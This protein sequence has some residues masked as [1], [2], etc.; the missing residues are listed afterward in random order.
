MYRFFGLIIA[1]FLTT[2]VYAVENLPS[3]DAQPPGGVWSWIRSWVGIHQLTVTVNDQDGNPVKTATVMVG[4]KP[5][6]PFE[7]NIGT[8]D[9]NGSITFQDDALE[10][11]IPVTTYAPGFNAYTIFDL[12]AEQLSIKLTPRSSTEAWVDATGSF[13]K[14]HPYKDNDDLVASGIFAPLLPLEEIINFNLQALLGPECKIVLLDETDIPCNLVF[15]RQRNLYGGLIPITMNKPS[16][17]MKVKDRR[18]Q[19]FVSLAG[20]L[21]L[22]RTMDLLLAGSSFEVAI[23]GLALRKIG[24]AMDVPVEGPLNLN[25]DLDFIIRSNQI[26]VE[27]ENRPIGRSMLLLSLADYQ[28]QGA[29]FIPTGIRVIPRREGFKVKKLSSVVKTGPLANARDVVLAVAIDLPENKNDN[30][31]DSK[32]IGIIERDLAPTEA[33][34]I[35]INSFFLPLDLALDSEGVHLSEVSNPRISPF[36]DFNLVTL[37]RE[38]DGGKFNSTHESIWTVVTPAQRRIITL[39]EL[40]VDGIIPDPTVTPEND[41]LYWSAGVFALA[42]PVTMFDYN[43]LTARDV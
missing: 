16:Y 43:H 32:L 13:S 11:P 20:D 26:E 41:K 14:W 5:G 23:D 27:V 15:P 19:D 30:D 31:N 1:L 38:I 36:P 39:P 4:E 9:E 18:T 3:H 2:Q 25:M 12:Q 42:K 6:T 21:P 7:G 17:K 24:L 37:R 28:S 29:Q 8:T 35:N 33:R 34:R 10:N 40:P 22:T